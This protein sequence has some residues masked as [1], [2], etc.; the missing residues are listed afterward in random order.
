MF[1]KKLKSEQDVNNV[2]K[3]EEKSYD[4][5][6]AIKDGN[7]SVMENL[8]LIYEKNISVEE[9]ITQGFEYINTIFN[10]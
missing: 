6:Y 3:I 2:L 4:S 9:K 5:F 8:K 7:N 1:G 10:K